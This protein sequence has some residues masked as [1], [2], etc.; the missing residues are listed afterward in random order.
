LD[1]LGEIAAKF[2]AMR[3]TSRDLALAQNPEQAEKH[4][5]AIRD[6]KL[7]IV[8]STDICENC[9]KDDA[10]ALQMFQGFHESAAAY[11]AQVSRL[12][13]L[14]RAGKN[15]EAIALLNTQEP[16][17]ADAVLEWLTA[18]RGLKLEAA[19]TTKS[20]NAALVNKATRVTM[21]AVLVALALVAGIGVPL[22]TSIV[23]P[24]AVV[25]AALGKVAAGDFSERVEA[26]SHDEIGRLAQALNE[27]LEKINAAM[28]SIGR[29]S[30]FLSSSS[31]EL[32]A[33]SR[34]M[35]SSAQQ[36]ASQ[37]TVVSGAASEVTANLESVATATEEMT[38]SIREI[39][40]NVTEASHITTSA[41]M[42]AQNANA[43]VAKLGVA[44]Q[45]I[46]QIIKVITSIAQ[47][48]NLLALNATIEA[49]RA[50][51]A[52]K[53]FAVVANEVK[54]LAKETSRATEDITRKIEVIQS[55]TEG[56]VV[57]IAKIST[58]I[59]QLN[60]ISGVIA[61]AVEEQTATTNEIA[62]NVTEAAEGG[63]RV[64]QNITAVAAAAEE[65]S[66]GA[67][68][69]QTAASDLARVAGELQQ[70]VSQFK[71]GADESASETSGAGHPA[72]P[73][74]PTPA[75]RTDVKLA[76]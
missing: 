8:K 64:A 5:A 70:L 34:Q 7:G 44:S 30:Q 10:G 12:I 47:Q 50:G 56:A 60:D 51:E 32:S 49:A 76:A 74:G 53:G 26:G 20:E 2:E 68:E 14:K 19:Q 31:T 22:T 69:T 4:A 37:S 36:T 54:E 45:E 6:L 57:A 73:A 43:T 58:V 42:T 55:D 23:R 27:A 39:A 38:S 24:I 75:L 28:W 40:K 67:S 9:H 1:R 29:H 46:G 65:T 25:A 59:S 52:G 66:G 21:A 48:T 13:E 62:R 15:P 33:V 35:T 16:K 17:A 11:N 41:V 72:D 71:C 3:R 18:F 61:T 63:K